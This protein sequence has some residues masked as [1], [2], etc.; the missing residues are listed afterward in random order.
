M[1]IGTTTS[2]MTN[3]TNRR[4][5]EDD[6]NVYWWESLLA[7]YDSDTEEEDDD[8]D[9]LMM[10]MFAVIELGGAQ[11]KVTTDGVIVANRLEPVSDYK[12]GSVHTL[13]EVMLVGSSHLTLV[14]MLFVV[15]A[16]VDIMVEEITRDAKVIVFKKRR[17]K[18]SQRKNGFRIDV[19]LLRVLDV[20][21]PEEYRNHAHIC[22]EIVDTLGEHFDQM[23]PVIPCC[24]EVTFSFAECGR[25]QVNTLTLKPTID[26]I[27]NW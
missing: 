15:G 25:L 4:R 8:D 23:P 14:G 26:R 9:D 1:I 18:N 11:F 27:E 20:R 6:D 3:A 13:K 12:I 19:S 10:I 24:F 16:E 2:M 21:M 7:N 17:R 22:R 5:R